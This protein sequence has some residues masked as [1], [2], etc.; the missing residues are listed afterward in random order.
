MSQES[1][2]GDLWRALNETAAMPYGAGQIAAAEQILRRADATGDAH[3][4]FAARMLGTTAYVWGGERGKSFVTFSWCLSDFDR[5]PAP[6]HERYTHELMWHFKTVIGS[7]VSFPDVPLDRTR[8]VLDDME[9]RYQ[10]AGHSPQ[11]IYKLRHMVARAIGD[12]TGAEQWYRRWVTAPRDELSDCGG[13]DPSAQAEY[14]AEQGRD[15][16]AVAL[17]EP[18]LAGYLSCSEQ[19]QGVLTALLV[20][21]VR[22][23]RIEQAADAHRRAYR[24]LRPNLADLAD[25]ADHVTFCARTGNEARGLEI[26]ERHLAWL[27]RAPSPDDAL[28]FAAAGALVLGRVAAA[29]PDMIVH[30]PAHGERPAAD[31]DVAVLE[32]ELAAEA[33]AIAARFDARNG[34]TFQ[35]ERLA[36]QL[37]AEPLA[38]Y[39]PLSATIRRRV[40]APAVPPDVPAGPTVVPGPAVDG[41]ALAA[42][43]EHAGVA[44]AAGRFDDA[45]DDYVEA[46]ALCAEQGRAEEGAHLRVD[47]ADAY[48]SA[49]RWLAAAEAGE[50][51]LPLLERFGA[52]DE[53]IRCRLLLAAAY[54]NLDEDD[55]ALAMID[56][57][58]ALIRGSDNGGQA[59]QA[60]LAHAHETAGELHYQRNDDAAGALRFVTAAAAYQRAG[61]PV[62]EL[63]ALRR[64]VVAWRWAD[65]PDSVLAT[66]ADADR[67]A[68]SLPPHL[69]KEPGTIW[70]LA[71]LGHEA[72]RS[73]LD[74]ERPVEALVRIVDVPAQFRSVEAFGEA[75]DA[76][77]LHSDILLELD[78]P[79]DAEPVLR[80]TIAGLPH[81]SDGSYLAAWRLVRALAALGRDADATALRVEYGFEEDDV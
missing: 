62:D 28:E 68:E 39:V 37:A 19:P 41:V 77:L 13:C 7:L 12:V 72:A 21:Y 69:A 81:D 25:I 15:E 4:R 17:V 76:D 73:L 24:L 53:V 2:A 1:E 56:A 45:I 65:E 26:L 14:L 38:D 54:R 71:T 51:A 64:A 32:A 18:V 16:E 27:D 29:H 47:L 6:Y 42:R 8:A 52:R 58:I 66:L 46:V 48:M 44:S 36:A 61:L 31:V 9:R 79:E 75:V 50:E 49:Y 23:G 30:R 70:E 40:S 43:V 55:D 67:V 63:R 57:A 35:S 20:P 80:A 60:R 11:A 59:D 78:R 3:V 74:L 34:T 33:R 22:T 10:E 5:A